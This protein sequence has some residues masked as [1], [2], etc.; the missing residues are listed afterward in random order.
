MNFKKVKLTLD[1]KP[2]NRKN[3]DEHSNP[4]GA[5][6]MKFTFNEKPSNRTNCSNVKE[7]HMLYVICR[8]ASAATAYLHYIGNQLVEM[9]QPPETND[10]KNPEQDTGVER[11][12][13]EPT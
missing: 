12:V 10:D 5:H 9:Y 2:T 1:G 6:K 8:H 3:E 11:M 4:I 7:E 13:M